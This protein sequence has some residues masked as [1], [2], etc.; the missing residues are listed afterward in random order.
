MP[1]TFN[2][3][4]SLLAAATFLPKKL[5]LKE[6]PTRSIARSASSSVNAMDFDDKKF[7]TL[8]LVLED[9][10]FTRDQKIFS[11]KLIKQYNQKILR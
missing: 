9:L 5:N 2:N 6:Q 3:F 7:E 4:S 10:K 8:K 1:V 11:D